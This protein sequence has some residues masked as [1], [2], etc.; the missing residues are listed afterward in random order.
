MQKG[1]SLHINA[2]PP[3]ALDLV[4]LNDIYLEEYGEANEEF[5]DD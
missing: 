3:S 4:R 2:S 5:N 1:R